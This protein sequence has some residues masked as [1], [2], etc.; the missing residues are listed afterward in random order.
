MKELVA[1]RF[2]SKAWFILYGKVS[3][4]RI[5]LCIQSGTCCIPIVTQVLNLFHLYHHVFTI[6]NRALQSLKG[7]RLGGKVNGGRFTICYLDKLPIFIPTF[8]LCFV[9]FV[10]FVNFCSQ[11]LLTL[12]GTG[13]L[14]FN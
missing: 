10:N 4:K 9:V 14:S 8:I 3:V 11:V 13:K 6:M 12:H 1:S 5:T 7:N 2:D